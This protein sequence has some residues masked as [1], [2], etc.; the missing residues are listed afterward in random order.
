MV[1]AEHQLA[2]YVGSGDLPVLATPMM[3]AMMENAAMMAVKD[4]V[5]EGNSTVGG[6]ISSSHIRPTGLGHVVMATA[7]LIAVDGR[8]LTFRVSACDEQGLI[9]EG[10]HIRFIV[11]REKFMA[12]VV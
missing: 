10:E 9:G 3:M 2:S 6:Q 8:K 5:G 11:S 1:V 12:K 7:E 4:A